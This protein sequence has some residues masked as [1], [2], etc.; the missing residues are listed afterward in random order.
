MAAYLPYQ[1]KPKS[2]A[3]QIREAEHQ[4]SN[5]QRKVSASGATLA[6]QIHQQM[7]TPASLMLAGGIGFILGE[8]TKRH[9]GK[10]QGTADKT[11][12]STVTVPLTTAINFITSAYTLYTA[13]LPLAW[14][15]K[16]LR[17]TCTQEPMHT[18]PYQPV[19]DA[20]G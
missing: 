10:A 2:L 1:L 5:R 17:Q 15:V 18:Q 20:S 7:T 19:A 16:P 3:T 14:M 9:T 8:L 13:V 4:V 11:R 12:S 6:R